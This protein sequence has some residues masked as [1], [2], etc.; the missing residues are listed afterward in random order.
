VA[1]QVAGRI[2]KV[3]VR[4]G[5]RV[6]ADQ[7]VA[8][9]DTSPYSDEVSEAQAAVDKARA[10]RANAEATLARVKRVVEHGIAARQELDDAQARFATARAGET[11]AAAGAR[12]A[13]LHIERATVRSP[14]AGVVLKVMRHSGESVDGTPATPV[15]EVGDPSRIELVGDAPGQDLI[16]LARGAAATVQVA[17]IRFPG[18]VAAVSPGVDRT[19]G[20]GVV[21]VALELPGGVAP[22]VGMFGIARIATGRPRRVTMIPAVAV[23]SATGPEGEVVVCGGD[24]IAHLTHA[25]TGV[26]EGDLIEVGDGIR[27]GD[28]VAVAPVLGL[29][30]GDKLE[31]EAAPRP[32]GGRAP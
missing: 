2:T 30:E 15:V 10:E 12:R 29:A 14:L 5:D 25:R 19:T 28:R 16:R 17:S 8:Q 13:R 32:D 26:R 24:G 21:R 1:P 11:Q 3:L 23:R 20:L 18:T 31:E 7:P 9:I 27:P 4:E 6:T 22:P